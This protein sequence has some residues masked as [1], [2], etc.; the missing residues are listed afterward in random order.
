MSSERPYRI[1][2]GDISYTEFTQHS[3]CILKPSRQICENCLKEYPYDICE[4]A[5]EFIELCKN[6][7]KEVYLVSG[8]Y[9]PVCDYVP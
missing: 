8:G 5:P 4:K 1:I 9:V 2:N 6:L 3:L 7:G